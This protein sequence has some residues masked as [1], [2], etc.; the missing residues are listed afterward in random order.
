MMTRFCGAAGAVLFAGVAFAETVT[1]SP[2]ARYGTVKPMNGVNNGPIVVRANRGGYGNSDTFA[3]AKIPF[4]RTHDSAF[5]ARY[6][7][8]HTVD[9]HRIFPI[10]EADENDPKS[11]DFACTDNYL[12][13][14]REAGAE[15]FYRLGTTIEH[16]VKKYG[17]VP[18]KDFAKW[19]R[20]CEHV[21]RHY[22][23]GWADGFKWNIRYWEIW[24][25]P[26][27]GKT[28][29]GGT[30]EQFFDLFETAAKHLKTCFPNL[31]IGGPALAWRED[32]GGKFLAEMAKRKVPLDFFSWHIYNANPEN[33]CNK[34]H[35][36]RRAMRENGYGEAESILNEWNYVKSWTVG[37]PETIQSII[38]TKGAVFEMC[39]M[40]ACQ[41]SPVDILMYY[42]ARPSVWNG[43]WDFYSLKP[44][45][46]YYPFLM[47]AKFRE[48]GSCCRIVPEERKVGVFAAAGTNGWAAAIY[49]FDEKPGAEPLPLTI[50]VAGGSMSGVKIKV[51]D[52]THAFED[53]PT[54]VEE[55]GTVR[56]LTI[57]P[58]SIVYLESPAPSPTHEDSLAAFRAA[59]KTAGQDVAEMA[60]GQASSMEH[61]RP[62]D[63][64]AAHPADAL[65][66]RLARGER[67]SVQLIVTPGEKDLTNVKVAVS[68]LKAANGAVLA[69]AAIRADVMGY[70][71][72]TNVP[73]YYVGHFPRKAE[74]GWWPD[75]ILDFLKTVDVKR[76]DVQ[77]FWLRVTCPR[78]QPAGTYEGTVMVTADGVKPR[79]VP[80]KVRVNDF[81]VPKASPLPLAITFQP[82]P[83]GLGPDG[84][85]DPV[86]EALKADPE[87]PLNQ[88]KAHEAEWGS[89]LA[90]YYITMDSLYHH[91]LP[92]IEVLKTLKK[93]GRLGWFNLGY[94]SYP[95]EDTPA[96][97][98][99]WEKD[100]LARLEKSYAAA[101]AAGLQDHAYLYGCDE[102]DAET[103]AR[104]QKALAIFREK[105][106]GVP[107]STTAHEDKYGIGTP[108]AG[109]DWFTPLTSVY[110]SEQAKLSRAAGH[111][112]WWYICCGPHAPHANMFIECPPVETRSL[113]G[114]QT[115]RMRP[116][117]FLYY[118][119]SIW[120]AKR[121]IASGPFTDWNPMS[122]RWYH[123]DGAWT[124][125][126]PGGKP[127]PTQRLE[128]FRDGL[129]DYAYV[130]LLEAKLAA[131]GLTAAQAVRARE[132]IAV[133][134]SVMRSMT[135]FSRNPADISAWRDEM[136]DLIE[137]KN[138]KKEN[139]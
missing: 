1:I 52:E 15:V 28:C 117:G 50:K 96:C 138:E 16:G 18:P 133:P 49:R 108:L 32:W 62:C 17:S 124:A 64:F 12:K 131:G 84:T 122:W 135:D 38:G 51:V 116:D 56:K 8:D 83:H 81:E 41:C 136:A 88:W 114:A 137:V 61:V 33:I 37:Y 48:L 40:V 9:I 39:T 65:A 57:A 42:D 30:T 85:T 55:D 94:W 97:W 102:V 73:P 27:E 132:L 78:E 91:G 109:M 13:E 120:N 128:N 24:N 87:S 11:Y 93:E 20:I 7:G 86:C 106:P 118:E 107:L 25:E 54:M 123:G 100:T 113:M 105:L 66:V 26:D 79:T 75:P 46:G 67:E 44:L 3:A 121:P 63:G 70:V 34:A 104:M 110:D 58:M 103:F 23:E 31:K 21:V 6:G 5:E 77:S 43:L 92:R 126:G 45:K 4:V 14:I 29:W 134:D 119:V 127:L 99:A 112:V 47:W 60:L 59:C 22:N 139:K 35:R 80:I 101:K 125:V 10:F 89:F 95:K 74:L 98:A 111:Q 129:E 72:C 90:D 36:M 76:G 69:S 2:Q 71:N 68:D 53:C 82:L 115:A 19:A 130:K